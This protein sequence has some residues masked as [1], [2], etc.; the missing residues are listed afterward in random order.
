M[1][2]Q[3]LRIARTQVLLGLGGILQSV[4]FTILTIFTSSKTNEFLLVKMPT[5]VG[6][7]TFIG[8]W[9]SS[10]FYTYKLSQLIFY[11]PSHIY[12]IFINCQNH[13]YQCIWV[14]STTIEGFTFSST[15][16]LLNLKLAHNTITIKGK[17]RITMAYLGLGVLWA[18]EA[19][20]WVKFFNR[21]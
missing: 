8:I 15:I 13:W 9:H 21:Y 1:F 17:E 7:T 20:E 14:G 5:N 4:V 19:I 10:N 12:Y 11:Y 18:M 2:R 16:W 3:F 6:I